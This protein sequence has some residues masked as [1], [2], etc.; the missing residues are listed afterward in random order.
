MALGEQ[1]ITIPLGTVLGIPL[2]AGKGPKLTLRFTPAGA[3][4][5]SFESAFADAGINQTIHKITLRL[6]ATVRIILP[7]ESHT[8]TISSVATIAESIIVGDVP[9]TYADVDDGEEILN[10]VP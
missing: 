5:S 10:L 6:T 9:S 8:V 7:G 1:G 4:Q 3:V 2:F